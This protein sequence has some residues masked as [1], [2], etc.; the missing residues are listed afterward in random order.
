LNK[1][2]EFD[3]YLKPTKCK[4]EKREIKYLRVII[5]KG[6]LYMDPEKLKGVH[7]YARP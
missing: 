3:L 1:L 7:K 5:R 6:H 4:F 2:E